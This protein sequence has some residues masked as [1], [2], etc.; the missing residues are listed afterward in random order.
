M[1]AV[2]AEV[3]GIGVDPGYNPDELR[4]GELPLAW[5]FADLCHQLAE[6]GT[7]SQRCLGS[8]TGPAVASVPDGDQALA[9]D[10]LVRTRPV[11]R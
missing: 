1:A 2:E 3:G 11:V 5:G 8:E 6:V 4:L 7:E 9:R 10:A